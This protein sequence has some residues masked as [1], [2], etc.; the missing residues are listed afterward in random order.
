MLLC[1]ENGKS[2]AL[3]VAFKMPYLPETDELLLNAEESRWVSEHP[4]KWDAMVKREFQHPSSAPCFLAN[5]LHSALA[6]YRQRWFDSTERYAPIRNELY[7]CILV[8]CEWNAAT[9]SYFPVCVSGIRKG[10]KNPKYI[11][12]A[13]ELGLRFADETSSTREMLRRVVR[14]GHYW[15]PQ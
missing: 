8:T 15:R 9:Q 4:E 10:C 14:E 5:H 12:T 6:K 1:R 11:G 3:G 13:A 7:R 2:V